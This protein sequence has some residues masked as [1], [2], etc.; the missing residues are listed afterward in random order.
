M[1]P[2]L[3]TFGIAIVLGEQT[4]MTDLINLNEARALK[5]S[6]ATLWT[7]EECLRAILRDL[8]SGELKPVDAIYVAMVRKDKKGQAEA[9]PF[10][11][12]GA[13]TL[14]LRGILSQHLHDICTA[15]ENSR[16]S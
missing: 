7:P 16:S 11:T 1:K 9:F 6:D 2:L 14:E 13:I 5:S 10:Y 15:F 8:E 4:I 3:P 12:A